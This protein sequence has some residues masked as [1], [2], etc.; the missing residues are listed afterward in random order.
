MGQILLVSLDRAREGDI[1]GQKN[2]PVAL[3]APIVPVGLHPE[4]LAMGLEW[5]TEVLVAVTRDLRGSV[6]TLRMKMYTRCLSTHRLS[7]AVNFCSH[8]L[9]VGRLDGHD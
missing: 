9:Y 3:H 1:N 5:A 7:P 4:E 2:V 6:T 8:V